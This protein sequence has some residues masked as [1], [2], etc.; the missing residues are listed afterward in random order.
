[1][2][3]HDRPRTISLEEQQQMGLRRTGSNF[4]PPSPERPPAVAYPV[5]DTPSTVIVERV[6]EAMPGADEKT[7]GMDRAWA[8]VT[9]ALPLYCTWLFLSFSIG[10]AAASEGGNTW[11]LVVGAIVLSITSGATYLYMDRQEWAH[12]RSGLEAHRINVAAALKSQE[13]KQQGE[14]KRRALDAYIDHLRGRP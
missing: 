1:M 5:Q 6:F 8:L 4:V 10:V 3:Y 2:N 14:L 13:L 7:S 12:S 9:R 11:G